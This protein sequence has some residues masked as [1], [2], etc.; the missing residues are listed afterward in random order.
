[1]IRPPVYE[2]FM[3]Y[4]PSDN[5]F[6]LAIDEYIHFRLPDK[7]YYGITLTMSPDVW[8]VSFKK[9]INEVKNYFSYSLSNLGYTGIGIIEYTRAHVPH[10]HG[11]CVIPPDTKLVDHII[12]KKKFVRQ[13]YYLDSRIDVIHLLDR[14]KSEQHM[15]S[16]GKYICK[17]LQPLSVMDYFSQSQV[18]E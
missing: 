11:L 16:V 14:I 1:M 7:I 5:M 15:R 8:R 13:L 6:R 12:T 17:T 3:V 10:L 18:I 4:S 9:D 2:K